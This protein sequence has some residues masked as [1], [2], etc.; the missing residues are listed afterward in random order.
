MMWHLGFYVLAV[1][2]SVTSLVT[3]D[4]EILA[5][6]LLMCIMGTLTEKLK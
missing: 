6:G 2:C 5:V 3:G 4:L 1:L